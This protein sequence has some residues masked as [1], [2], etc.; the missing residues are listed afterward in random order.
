MA[1]ARGPFGAVPGAVLVGERASIFEAAGSP[2][3]SQPSGYRIAHELSVDGPA[4]NGA[5]IGPEPAGVIQA[6]YADAVCV[7][8]TL[9]DGV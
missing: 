5:A 9:E 7:S 3:F 4:V 2:V 1:L 6:T 8:G